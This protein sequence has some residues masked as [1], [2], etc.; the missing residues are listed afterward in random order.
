MRTLTEV[1]AP[2]AP[3]L[4]E[5][6]RTLVVSPERELE[7]GM[8]VRATFTFRNQGGA[9]ATGV[10]VRFNVPDG[11]V[12]LVGT[13]QLDGLELDDE[14]G[15]SPLLSR[16][17]AHIG[18][19]TPGQERT[20][21][22][23]YSVAGAIENGSTVEL[24][25][26]V[27]AFELA[28]VGSNVVRLIARSKPALENALTNIVIEGRHD[29]RPGG[30]ATVTVRIHNAGESSAHD[31]VAV[32]PIPEFSSYIPN[33]VRVNGRELERDLPGAFDR[34]H[35]P[36]VVKNLPA[37]ATATLTYRI[38]IADPLRN[39]TAI[40]A[41]AHI[42]SQEIPAFAL[43]P[44]SLT[45]SAAPEF[46]DEETFCSVEPLHDVEPGG[47]V[48]IR[49]RAYNSG[50]TT[51]ENVAVAIT[52]A[53]GLLPVRGSA[54]VDG[55]PLRDRKKD[56]LTY[57]LG[58][59][60]A[61]VARELQADAIV[62]SPAADGDSLRITV[63]LSWS[64]SVKARET[65]ERAFEQTVTV[66]SAPHLAS[67]RNRIER[68][69]RE[70]VHPSD[71][72]EA[73]ISIDNDGSAPATDAVLQLHVDPALDDVRV[74]EKNAKPV[75][76]GDS[77]DLGSIEP[78]G[79]RRFTVRA[80]VR[81]PYPDRS[82]VR[83]GASLHTHELGETALGE[84]VYRVDSHPAFLPDT[85]LLELVTGEILRPNQL[86]DVF[87]QVRNEGT[88][89]AQNVRMRLYVS[90]EAR[91][92]SV[93]GATRERSTLIFG[94][95]APGAVAKARL[96]LRLMR[97]L[98]KEYPVTVDGVLTAEAMLPVQLNRLTIVTTAEP[99]FAVGTF[100][101]EPPEVADVGEMIDYVLHLRNGGDGP[102]RR[103]TL[104][105]DA[106]DSLIYVP[107]S[108]TVN[109]VPVRDVGAL[110]PFS[111]D[112]GIAFN[113]VDPGIEATI[114]WRDVVHNGLAA[115]E[116]IVRVAHVRYDGDRLDH[117][118]SSEL[119]VRS[120]PVFANNIP[121]LPFGLDGMVGPSFAGGPRALA[122]AQDRVLELPPATA[123]E[124]ESG[125]IEV[126]SQFIPRDAGVPAEV[127]EARANGSGGA[128][129]ATLASFTPERL[130]RALRFLE[131]ARFGGFVSHLFAIRAFVPNHVAG[132]DASVLEAERSSLRES[133]DRLFIKLR[134]PHYTVAPRDLEVPAGRA[135]LEQFLRALA[136][137]NAGVPEST[138]AHAFR[139]ELHA[140]ELVELR[141]RVHDAPLGTALPWLALARCMPDALPELRNY[142]DVLSHALL[143]LVPLD[144]MAFT[145]ALQRRQHPVLDAALDVV[146]A[147]L[148][149]SHTR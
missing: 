24:Q 123:I 133:L 18:D 134:L 1:F 145:E 99:N 83:L 9:T 89:V 57:D 149:A 2:G 33:S 27:A 34:V 40:L 41:R 119:K 138:D 100:R 30:D 17:G 137:G 110:A 91:L 120:A 88:D 4:P 22:I 81:S 54:R 127:A 113:D 107:N 36:V 80:R 6:L 112:R 98:A 135:T 3:S 14:Q 15:N 146:R 108:T 58:H 31:V 26:A 39:G 125:E 53:D 65:L 93:D 55:R 32:A 45:V 126:F 85:S 50:S 37:S 35:A 46:S 13:G 114:R 87:V 90:P 63:T 115:G 118:L 43:V 142:R 5:G 124:A 104:T 139:G 128:A 131:E 75:L 67:R 71:E 44:A 94:E 78:Y 28:P 76:D 86:A 82:E 121:G 92:E 84:A 12:Y 56:S 97:S 101:S 25:A 8:T 109:D 48:S 102:A 29:V 20:I 49:V 96:G 64:A 148:S 68:A 132:V 66:K 10:R 11:L 16:S 21:A 23:G 140:G 69:S 70:M 47:R 59:I 116:A 106:L 74:G 103:V 42:A 144:A 51:A 61:R 19:V 147:N 38:R 122:P 60:E 73:I 143:D 72:I 7:P 105:V 52:L 62:A 130:E 141:T 136:S 95:I 129:V 117:I 111:S 79:A 77:V